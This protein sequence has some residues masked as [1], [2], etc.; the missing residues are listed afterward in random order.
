MRDQKYGLSHQTVGL[1]VTNAGSQMERRER[2]VDPMSKPPGPGEE[3]GG[4]QRPDIGSP[5]KD[6]L[7]ER[8][9]RVDPRQA[10]RYRQRTGE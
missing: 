2:P 8:M 5:D 4:P 3:G 9:R 10:E 7:L 6:K 1:P